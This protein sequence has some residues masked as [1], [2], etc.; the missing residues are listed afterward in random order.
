LGVIT[1][2]VTSKTGND[3]LFVDDGSGPAR[4]CLDGYNGDFDD[5]DPGIS[6]PLEL[7]FPSYYAGKYDGELLLFWSFSVVS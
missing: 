4:V 2:R 7:L 1:G 5:F 3:T 6:N